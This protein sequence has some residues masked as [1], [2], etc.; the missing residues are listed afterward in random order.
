MPPAVFGGSLPNQVQFG[1]AGENQ[2][3]EMTAAHSIV[4]PRPRAQRLQWQPG[5][6]GLPTEQV[7]NALEGS[8]LDRRVALA[9]HGEEARLGVLR[10]RV[11]LLNL[12]QARRDRESKPR[13]RFVQR[14]WSSSRDSPRDES[15]C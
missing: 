7:V 15:T 9:E 10:D 4:R 5:S 1:G 8:I 13:S 12:P 11:P 3:V 2:I 14:G 6:V